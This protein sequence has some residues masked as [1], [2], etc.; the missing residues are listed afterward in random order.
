MKLCGINTFWLFRSAAQ[1]K[2]HHSWSLAIWESFCSNS[3]TSL[4][5]LGFQAT[6]QTIKR[7]LAYK[8]QFIYVW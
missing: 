1:S 8:N 6:S 7:I 5:K 2:V 4:S 3:E